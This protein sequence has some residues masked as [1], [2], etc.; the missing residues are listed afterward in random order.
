M[1]PV[2]RV[3][4]RIFSLSELRDAAEAFAVS[5]TIGVVGISHIDGHWI[6]AHEFEGAAGPT[7]LALNEML[8]VARKPTPGS[9]EHT[10]VPY[11]YMTGMLS[12]LI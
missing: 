2:Q 8:I 12:Q 9:S 4:R 10:E 11:G 3:E 6:G 1:V 7:S 5:S